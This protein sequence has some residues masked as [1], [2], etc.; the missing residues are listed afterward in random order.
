MLNYSWLLSLTANDSAPLGLLYTSPSKL[1]AHEVSLLFVQGR[2]RDPL[3]LKPRHHPWNSKPGKFNF[4]WTLRLIFLFLEKGPSSSYVNRFYESC[5][6]AESLPLYDH[7]L[8]IM[9]VVAEVSLCLKSVTTRSCS[10]FLEE[11][12]TKWKP[13]SSS[14]IK[15]STLCRE[16]ERER[17]DQDLHP[18]M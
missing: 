18:W 14:F 2:F 4:L 10:K 16:I 6:R 1:F 17:M 5:V 7:V 8:Q 3:N 12:N 11:D 13:S 15:P 9:R